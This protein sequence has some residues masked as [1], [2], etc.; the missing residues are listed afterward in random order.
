[1]TYREIVYAV[2]DQLKLISDDTYITE[3]HALFLLSKVRGAIL[4]QRYSDIRKEIPAS[5]YQTICLELEPV[6]SIAG[7][8]CEGSQYL[9]SK[10]KIPSTISIGTETIYPVDFYQ[11][12]NIAYISK[13]RMRFVGHNKWLQNIIYASLGPDNYLYFSSSNPQFLYLKEVR[14][15]G[16]F[17]DTEEAANLE[18]CENT[19]DTPCDI[20]DKKFPLEEGL[21]TTVIDITLKYLSAASYAPRDDANDAKDEL[22]DIMTFIKR[23]MK[24]NFQKQLEQ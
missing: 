15:T 3:E 14:M 19:K 23:N 21:V 10:E 22:S 8:S 7:E 9:R 4:K 2:L 16:I 1:M 18:H 17:E 12:V 6:S 20:L 11:G 13:E 5:N 24:S